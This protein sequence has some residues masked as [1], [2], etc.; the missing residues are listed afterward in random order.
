MAAP[1]L[2]VNLTRR[3]LLL[4]A[5]SLPV[6]CL[7]SLPF[8]QGVS[9][10]QPF[11][12]HMRPPQVGQEW[13][14]SIKN[15][16]NGLL[17]DTVTE[18]V[19]AVGA[20]I[21]ISRVGQKLGVLPDEIQSPR[22]YIL[23]DPHWN[24]PQQF[25]KTIPLWPEELRV[26]WSGFYRT[27]Y[28]VLGYPDNSYYWGLNIDAQAWE[29]VQVPAGNFLTLKYHSSAPQFQSNDFSRL[30][31]WR[32]ED[33]WLSPKIGRWVIRR[34]WGRYVISGVTAGTAL[35]EDYLESELLSWK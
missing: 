26:G 10:P 29:S 13:V 6:A 15:V 24:P 4:T 31:N 8:P 21:R 30:A 18:R 14:Y 32:D 11:D 27:R 9:E 16:F 28:E 33:V 25:Q 19:E 17:M 22:G 23:Q 12:I 3:A 1:E 5:A 2:Q 20:Q 35:F 34:S 7:S